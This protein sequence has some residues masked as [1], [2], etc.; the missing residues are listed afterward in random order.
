VGN[1]F[2]EEYDGDYFPGEVM[3]YGEENDFRVSVM[4]SAGNNW[5]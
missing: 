5:K 3:E 2:L 1:W 4:H